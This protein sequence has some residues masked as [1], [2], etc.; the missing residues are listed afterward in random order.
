MVRDA[1]FL[2]FSNAGRYFSRQ[3]VD[4]DKQVGPSGLSDREMV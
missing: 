2:E 4:G 1:F 3:D